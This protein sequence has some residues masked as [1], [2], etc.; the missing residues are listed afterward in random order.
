MKFSLLLL[1][2]LT[3]GLMQSAEAVAINL[4]TT[5]GGHRF[6]VPGGAPLPNTGT[7]QVGFMSDPTNASSFTV[8][9]STAIHGNTVFLTGLGNAAFN[10][11]DP[12]LTA[13]ANQPIY[14]RVYDGVSLAASTL[15]GIW[16]SSTVLY[17]ADL[18][19]ASANPASVSLSTDAWAV[20]SPATNWNFAAASYATG[21]PLGLSDAQVTP[22]Q[23][24]GTAYTLGAVVPEPSSLILI[25][26]LGVAGLRRRR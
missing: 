21:A 10:S 1:S 22:T 3:L 18:A 9:G 14:I 20:V 11:L 25:S 8:F 16:R 17:P 5:A 26:L 7:I 4:A 15:A 2:V 24:T 23:R 6:L 13:A 12:G 19:P